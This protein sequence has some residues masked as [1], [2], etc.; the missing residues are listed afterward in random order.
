[1]LGLF[2]SSWV[3]F[4]VLTEHESEAFRLDYNGMLIRGIPQQ[5]THTEQG[6]CATVPEQ[7]THIEQALCV[8]EQMIKIE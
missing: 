1:M 3:L 6:L 5:M 8:P 2:K 4:P 7:I